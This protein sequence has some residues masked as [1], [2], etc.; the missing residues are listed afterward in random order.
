MNAVLVVGCVFYAFP[1]L[2]T[3]VPQV[4]HMPWVAGLPFF[5]T[6]DLGFL[7]STLVLHFMQYAS[8]PVLLSLWSVRS[9]VPDKLRGVNEGHWVPG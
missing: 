5:M 2:N 9:K 6:M 3:L 1:I 7:I 8:M 4:G